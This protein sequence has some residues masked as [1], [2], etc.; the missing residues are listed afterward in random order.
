MD[1]LGNKPLSDGGGF[2]PELHGSVPPPG[3]W[4]SSG[5]LGR[6]FV[7][8]NIKSSRGD[9][10]ANDGI[11]DTLRTAF[12]ISAGGAAR[13]A[14]GRVAVTRSR[15]GQRARRV[16]PGCPIRRHPAGEQTDDRE[17]DGGSGEDHGVPGLDAEQHRLRYP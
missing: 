8:H 11:D 2:R 17:R 4:M 14:H 6:T 13:R 5:R 12:V 15:V 1:P 9:L 3:G 10:L 7:G 16:E